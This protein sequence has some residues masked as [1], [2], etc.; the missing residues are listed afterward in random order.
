MI[1]KFVN[2]LNFNILCY[3]NLL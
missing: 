1:N 3:F 2:T